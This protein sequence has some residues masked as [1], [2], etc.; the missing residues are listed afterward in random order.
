MNILNKLYCI[1]FGHAPSLIPMKGESKLFHE[2][3]LRCMEYSN[4]ERIWALTSPGTYERAIKCTCKK[5]ALMMICDCSNLVLK[6]E[7]P[8]VCSRCLN[9]NH[10][11]P[12]GIKL[13]RVGNDTK[14]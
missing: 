11:L 13:N 8:E 1:S 10:M 3:C 5:G 9:G 2:G 14:S 4:T 6:G 12:K 7:F